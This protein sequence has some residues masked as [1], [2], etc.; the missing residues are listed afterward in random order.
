[1]FATSDLSFSA[2]TTLKILLKR[3]KLIKLNFI[4]VVSCLR[5]NE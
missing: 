1:M 4:E 5:F 2:K 3:L